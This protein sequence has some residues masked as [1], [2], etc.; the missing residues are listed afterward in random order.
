MDYKEALNK[1]LLLCASKELSTFKVRRKLSNWDVDDETAEKIINVLTKNKFLD[2]ERFA[3][4]YASSKFRLE[5]WGKNKIEYKLSY[6][7][8]ITP[9]IIDTAL[10][11]ILDDEYE[12]SCEKLLRDKLNRAKDTATFRKKDFYKRRLYLTNHAYSKGFDYDLI[13][14]ILSKR[15]F[16]ADLNS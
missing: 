7:Y 9:D 5:K 3:V 4:T 15:E 11:K 6:F 8:K 16:I 2:D 10:R 12:E 13:K 14:R 1:A